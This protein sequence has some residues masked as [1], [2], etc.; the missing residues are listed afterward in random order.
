MIPK[1]NSEYKSDNS[2]KIMQTNWAILPYTCNKIGVGL[3]QLGKH[4]VLW[5]A[6]HILRR[7]I[8]GKIPY[9]QFCYDHKLFQIN[10]INLF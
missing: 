3:F 5:Q 10:I 8:S 6:E 4:T 7:K 1:T 9:K 2:C